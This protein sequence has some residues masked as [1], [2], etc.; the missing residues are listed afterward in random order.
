MRPGEK[1]EIASLLPFSAMGETQREQIFAASFLQVFPPQ[2][3][4][5]HE[6]QEADFLH[7]LIDGQ[8]ELFAS[9]NGR[10][11]TLKI[12]EPVR[13]FI[14]AAVVSDL[15]YLMSARTLM[16][17]RVML[18]PARLLREMVTSDLALMQATMNEL[19]LGFREMVSALKNLKLRA[20]TERLAKLLLEQDL[21]QDR[22]GLVT[23]N[24][25]KRLIASLL[26]MSP[27]SLSRSFAALTSH[28][29]NSQGSVIHITDRSALEHFLN[30]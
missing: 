10:D 25:E 7:I 21:H 15:P 16:A 14:L 24:T 26:G 20:S 28:G 2:L 17:S 3:V 5:F 27:E 23:L 6:K 1:P 19:A 13:S 29:V 18:I 12:V 22:E 4:L 8:I 9:A 11:T 30:A